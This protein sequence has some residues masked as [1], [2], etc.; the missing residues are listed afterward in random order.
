MVTLV[1]PPSEVFLGN[2]N[3]QEDVVIHRHLKSSKLMWSA[4]KIT[5][6]HKKPMQNSSRD[7]LAHDVQAQKKP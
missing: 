7:S 4:E 1:K 3:G 2:C 5:S 6:C